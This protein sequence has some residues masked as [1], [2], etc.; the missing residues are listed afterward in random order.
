VF[1]EFDGTDWTVKFTDVQH[2]VDALVSPTITAGGRLQRGV[3][4]E[5]AS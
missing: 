4:W 3:I 2:R 1:V 5:T